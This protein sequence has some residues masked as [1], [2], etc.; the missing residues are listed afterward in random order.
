VQTTA[1][2]EVKLDPPRK[3]GVW[4]PLTFLA[5]A[6]ALACLSTRLP[7]EDGLRW[8]LFGLAV[9]SAGVAAVAG[10][11]VVTR[12]TPADRA[13]KTMEATTDGVSVRCGLADGLTPEAAVRIVGDMLAR[14]TADPH[15]KVPR[16]AGVFPDGRA[17]TGEPE[18]LSPSELDKLFE[19]DLEI[20]AECQKRQRTRLAELGLPD[21]GGDI[22]S[23]ALAEP[24]PENTV[25]DVDT[26][27]DSRP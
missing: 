8:A 21:P 16:P 1:T 15:M 20:Y 10:I 19:K 27:P 12:G 22:R 2:V 14:T 5:L 18:L 25:P 7:V 26:E 9:V 13:T 24:E 4:I 17:A 3:A 23:L 6:F 11:L